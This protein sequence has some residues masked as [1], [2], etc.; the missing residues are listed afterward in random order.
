MILQD[1][2]ATITDEDGTVTE[3]VVKSAFITDFCSVP[4]LPFIYDFM[5]NI[6]RKA[7]A[8]HDW[9]YKCAEHPRDW[10][11]NVLKAAL[12]AQGVSEIKAEEMYMAVRLF[13]GSHY[14]TKALKMRP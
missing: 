3:I 1:L 9:L 7:G 8:L 14:G 10:C 2:T 5:G 4:R 11:D 12:I 13:G 6:A